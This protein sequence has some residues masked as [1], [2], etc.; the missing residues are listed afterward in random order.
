MGA[1]P[2]LV[3]VY[4]ALTLVL[5]VQPASVAT[6]DRVVVEPTGIGLVYGTRPLT[7]GER[8]A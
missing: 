2:E 4:V 7:I 8:T 1:G 6:A 3:M 5:F